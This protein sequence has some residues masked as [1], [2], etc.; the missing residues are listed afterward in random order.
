MVRRGAGIRGRWRTEAAVRMR[1]VAWWLGAAVALSGLGWWAWPHFQLK[2]AEGALS[3]WAAPH[4]LYWP[5]QGVEAV[6]FT[7]IDRT[8]A[9]GTA[10]L[11]T[12]A[13][14]VESVEKRWGPTARTTYL[15]GR[16]ASL[17]GSTAEAVRLM[18]LAALLDPEDAGLQMA[19]GVSLGIRATAENRAIDWA[20]A[21]DVLLQ[22]AELPEFPPLGYANLAQASEQL[23]APNAAAGYWTEALAK[24]GG[25]WRPGFARNRARLEAE[26]TARRQRVALVSSQREPS[27]DIPGSAEFLLQ[28]ALAEWLPNRNDFRG[29]LARVAEHF[30]LQLSDP[31]LHDLLAASPKPEADQA[32]ARATAANAKG[33]Y[34]MAAAAGSQ[35]VRLYAEANNG[36]G[37]AL[38]G[39]QT[40]LGLR[41]SGRAPE[42]R[43]LGEESRLLARSRGYRWAELRA[44]QDAMACKSQQR[45]IDVL[46]EREALAARVAGSGFLDLELRAESSLIEP[47]RGF[48]AP[49][50]SWDRAQRGLASYGRSVLPAPFAV[51]FLSPLGMM[52]ESFG[53]PRLASLLFRE[54]MAAMEDHE[55]QWLRDAIRSDFFRLSSSAKLP[56]EA[57]GDIELAAQDLAAGR[58]TQALARLRRVTN[59]SQFPYLRLERYERIRLLPVLG[60]AYWQ[61]GQREEA[62][63][64]FRVLIDETVATVRVLRGRRQRY[65]TALEVGPA[66]RLLTDAQLEAEGATAALRTWQTFRTLPNPGQAVS[67]TPPAG[68]VRVALALLPTGPVVWWADGRGIAVH[69]V[70]AKNLTVRAQRLAGLVA[71]P[72]SPLAMVNESAREIYDWL[73]APFEGRLEGAKTLV[74]DPDGPLAVVPWGVLRDRKGRSLLSR[75]A[76]VQT[77]GWGTPPGNSP[78]ASVPAA[79]DWQPALVVAEPAV[80]PHD[81]GRFPELAA[82]RGEAEHLR[83]IFPRNSYLSG[84]EARVE[85]L[86]QELGNHQLFHFA[87]HGVANGGNG[88]LVL[89]S[90][91]PV[92]TRIITASEIAD[93]DLH[94]LRLATLASC[95]S[96]SGEDR[97]TVNVESLVQ[98][99]LDAGTSRVLASRWNVDSRA[100]S[101]VMQPFYEGLRQGAAP[102]SALRA[103][104]L[105]VEKL[106]LQSH[107]Y[108][109]AAFQM[110]GLP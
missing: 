52:A 19:Y 57:S 64:H 67:L 60:R 71:N 44:G 62:L 35:A 95:S 36:A 92:G 105:A 85:A 13:S 16:L 55:N 98:A 96:G 84:T 102:A 50:E 106:P 91:P 65:A 3:R 41:R 45:A 66:W 42:C 94:S 70:A 61:Q 34:R 43:A 78:Q 14:A 27:R 49:V 72:G 47:S 26:K 59:G 77:I 53:Y 15:R 93:L 58:G 30:R 4:M 75:V 101:R 79:T 63:R 110:F 1:R 32:L 22:A 56:G 68:E 12:V 90:E 107:P 7:P 46:A 23:P 25:L 83:T 39:V 76:I 28:L 100:T 97:G 89:A 17:R 33:D 38:A 54:A 20:T 51:N 10:T 2:R 6:V 81:R 108:Y 31:A 29:D 24:S 99:F 21:V 18:H 48:T 40:I 37:R 82:A 109:W 88:A 80:D 104:Q 9:T 11:A 103:A 69:R 74:V 5:G 87:G 8:S 86:Q 73:V